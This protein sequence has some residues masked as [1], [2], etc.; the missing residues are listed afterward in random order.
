MDH[1]LSISFVSIE[2]TD[3]TIN[4]RFN[5]NNL[6][7]LNKVDFNYFLVKPFS[8]FESTKIF[9]FTILPLRL[10]I[11]IFP[12][13]IC[14]TYPPIL[15]I[16]ILIPTLGVFISFLRGSGLGVAPSF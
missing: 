3:I 12:R 4:I 1:T 14:T 5:N 11:C 7:T 9:L 16:F 2:I 6:H 10:P 15:F 13:A 8:L